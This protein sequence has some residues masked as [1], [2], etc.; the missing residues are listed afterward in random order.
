[1]TTA[2]TPAPTT[3]AVAATPT[4]VKVRK[5]RFALVADYDTVLAT[6]AKKEQFTKDVTKSLAS[7]LKVNESRIV[8]MTFT[9]GSIIVQFSLIPS[10]SDS[11]ATMTSKVSALETMVKSGIYTIKL[12]D[13]TVLKADPTSIYMNKW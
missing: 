4:P 3:K 10:E 5:I 7:S 8:N 13:G 1:V 6:A 11:E 2:A 9:K 12:S